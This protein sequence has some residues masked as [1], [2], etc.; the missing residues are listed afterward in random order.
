MDQVIIDDSKLITLLI[1]TDNIARELNEV[2]N[3]LLKTL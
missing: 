3:E 1:N 2:N